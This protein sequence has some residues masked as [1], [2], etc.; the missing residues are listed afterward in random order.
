M[1]SESIIKH[2]IPGLLTNEAWYGLFTAILAPTSEQKELIPSE[3]REEFCDFV[4]KELDVDG[5]LTTV[6]VNSGTEFYDSIRRLRQNLR[7]DTTQSEYLIDRLSILVARV[8]STGVFTWSPLRFIE[9]TETVGTKDPVTAIKGKMQFYGVGRVVSFDSQKDYNFYEYAVHFDCNVPSDVIG[10]EDGVRI[11]DSEDFTTSSTGEVVAVFDKWV[12]VRLT[13]PLEDISKVHYYLVKRAKS[14]NHHTKD[15]F[16]A[17]EPVASSAVSTDDEQSMSE[18]VEAIKSAIRKSI[19]YNSAITTQGVVSENIEF[20][21][22]A[23]PEF[24]YNSVNTSFPVKPEFLYDEITWCDG[25]NAG[26][27]I[28]GKATLPEGKYTRQFTI[29]DHTIGASITATLHVNTGVTGSYCLQWKECTCVEE[30]FDDDMFTTDGWHDVEVYPGAVLQFPMGKKIHLRWGSYS[31]YLMFGKFFSLDPTN[32]CIWIDDFQWASFTSMTQACPNTTIATIYTMLV[33]TDWCRAVNV[34]GTNGVDFKIQV[35]QGTSRL[36]KGGIYLYPGTTGE[37]SVPS[38][39]VHVGGLLGDMAKINVDLATDNV[40]VSQRGVLD[41]TVIPVTVA[42]GDVTYNETLPKY[43]SEGSDHFFV[44]PVC[45][46]SISISNVNTD[47]TLY[48]P[49]GCHTVIAP[50]E[51]TSLSKWLYKFGYSYGESTIECS[52]FITQQTESIPNGIGFYPTPHGSLVNMRFLNDGTHNQQV[53]YF[54]VESGSSRPYQCA[55]VGAPDASKRGGYGLGAGFYNNTTIM[56]VALNVYVTAYSVTDNIGFSWWWDSYNNDAMLTNVAADT[57]NP[58]V[59]NYHAR[60]YPQ[61]N[62]A[63]KMAHVFTKTTPEEAGTITPPYPTGIYILSA[64]VQQFTFKANTGYTLSG[65]RV[66]RNGEAT[67]YSAVEEL[68]VTPGDGEVIVEALAVT[69]EATFTVNKSDYGTI[70]NTDT[71]EEMSGEYTFSTGTVLNLRFDAID[72]GRRVS[73][74]RVGMSDGSVKEYAGNPVA[75]TVVQGMDGQA[76]DVVT[77]LYYSITTDVTGGGAITTSPDVSSGWAKAGTEVTFTATPEAEYVLESLTVNG[78]VMSSPATVTVNQNSTVKAVFVIDPTTTYALTL[79]ADPTGPTLTGAGSYV[80]GTKVT[81]SAEAET[82]TL[83]FDHWSDDGD[84]EHVV[85]IT[86]DATLTAYYVDLPAYCTITVESEDET[87]GFV[88][89]GGQIRE[90]SSCTVTATAVTGYMFVEWVDSTGSH[91]SNLAEYTFEVTGDITL[92]AIFATSTELTK[93]LCSDG[94]WVYPVF[95]DDGYTVKSIDLNGKTPIGV[96]I[97]PASH[98]PEN[99]DRVLSFMA[100]DPTNVEEGK[101]GNSCDFTITSYV[102]TTIAPSYYSKYAT[103]SGSTS[104]SQCCFGTQ[105]SSVTVTNTTYLN[106]NGFYYYSSSSSNNSHVPVLNLNGDKNDSFGVSGTAQSQMDGETDTLYHMSNVTTQ[107]W[108]SLT[109]ISNCGGAE[110]MAARRFYTEGTRPGD[111]YVMSIG[112]GF[113]LMQFIDRVYNVFTALGKS[114]PKGMYSDRLI[115]ST[116]AGN[117][118]LYIGRTSD[119][120]SYS[121]NRGVVMMMM[122]VKSADTATVNISANSTGN[123]TVIYEPTITLGRKTALYAIPDAGYKFSQ[124]TDGNTDQLRIIDADG[125]KTYTAEFVQKTATINCRIYTGSSYGTISPSGTD[126]YVVGSTI[127]FKATPNQYCTVDYIRVYAGGSYT[128]YSKA[129]EVDVVVTEDMTEIRAAFLQTTHTIRITQ[130]TGG[131]VTINNTNASIRTLNEGVTYTL[132]ATPASGYHF[133]KWV[134]GSTVQSRTITC[135]EDYTWSAVF[136]A[137]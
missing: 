103:M 115:T 54:Q 3:L 133:S 6:V 125:D 74:W 53:M 64:E 23:I 4:E 7:R 12:V 37:I 70:I 39:K 94:S 33:G 51:V 98:T 111:W 27:I 42:Y 38:G 59:S 93:V 43:K 110:I 132:V 17:S 1:K 21:E 11:S 107:D 52:K 34:W 66:T 109:D 35:V 124:W 134:D 106:D 15:V 117:K 83:Q 112:E 78:E 129:T 57:V 82:D 77:D 137:D 30:E 105:A 100:A 19:R 10:I 128:T 130:S 97:V 20:I 81:V 95:E 45:S 89:G 84:R 79:V 18:I 75:I 101:T 99:E 68:E 41:T 13:E 61:F 69:G 44:V 29:T 96:C 14:V 72:E 127:E 55:I 31:D 135:L 50:W 121:T 49:Y 126:T 122:K 123:G 80:S 104:G 76:I 47:N 120:A 36:S 71:S 26:R 102:S 118:G 58:Y 91:V 63:D 114:I 119:Y 86:E 116:P 131:T 46:D 32:Q 90:G 60:I 40:K 65:W 88:S 24:G 16:L 56:S 48:V 108:R 85:T 73:S 25:N 62:A 2:I 136:E 113:Y 87:K 67:E 22:D 5:V 92:K 28:N 9:G 8:I